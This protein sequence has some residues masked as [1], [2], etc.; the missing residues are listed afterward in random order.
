[1]NT[2]KIIIAVAFLINAVNSFDCNM[3]P[4]IKKLFYKN[5]CYSKYNKNYVSHSTLIKNRRTRK[6]HY[7]M[8]ETNINL[9]NASEPITHP[10]KLTHD[11]TNYLDNSIPSSN[12]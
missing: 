7:K 10:S 4:I 3:F 11:F 12:N 8:T 2:I 5:T 9:R 1:M 6:N